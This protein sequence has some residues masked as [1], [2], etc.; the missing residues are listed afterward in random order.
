LIGANAGTAF[1]QATPSPAPETTALPPTT[2]TPAPTPAPHTSASPNPFAYSGYVRSYYFTRTN[3][4]NFPQAA[5]QI[6]QASFNTAINLHGQYTFT[7]NLTLGATYL[8]ANPVNNCGS[9][10]S[11][12]DPASGC[13]SKKAFPFKGTNAD[14]TLPGFE[15]NALYEY[16]AQ[17]K[18]ASW[19]A[20]VGG[21]VV[22]NPWLNP[23]DSRL[24]PNAFQ[25]A[26]A[27]Y[28][29]NKDWTG[30]LAYFWRYED[31][32]QSEFQDATLLTFRPASADGSGL[33][34]NIVAPG[35]ITNSGAL[36]GRLGYGHN[37]LSSNLYYYGFDKIANTIWL[38]GKY[39][40]KTPIKPFVAIQFANQR[41][42]GTAILG[43]I[44]SDVYGV[45]GGVSF[46][47]NVDVT[48]GYDYIP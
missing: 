43:K 19:L 6:N 15:L 23:S 2:S 42:T 24:K 8:Y 38:D 5:H 36:Y 25:G 21:Q 4:S 39:S 27:A 16:Y 3:Q 34:S 17:Y 48:L 9:A 33:P 32:V 29:F 1:A 22:N 41:S 30:E 20:K 18:D 37:A 14:D 7:G 44:A 31:R 12:L 47:P 46:G 10:S 28:K 26:D 35:T 40:W 45:Q 11:H 13:F